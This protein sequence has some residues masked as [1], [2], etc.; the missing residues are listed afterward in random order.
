MKI[1]VNIRDNDKWPRE[2]VCAGVEALGH[3][4]TTK[5]KIADMLI[6]WSP[7]IGSNR[8]AVMNHYIFHQKPILIMENGWIPEI[9]E[10]KYYQVAFNGWNG[11]GEFYIGDEKRWNSWKLPIEPWRE[12]AL[13]EKKVL[14]ISQNGH[15]DD[16][17]TSPIGWVNSVEI[18]TK[19]KVVRTVKKMRPSRV[20]DLWAGITWSSNYAADLIRRG[21]PVFAFSPS[22]EILNLLAKQT[23]AKNISKDLENSYY[24][25]N[26]L[27]V[28]KDMAW[29][30][31]SEKE[32][33]TGEP[34]RLQIR[35]SVYASACAI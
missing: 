35:N 16:D 27:E 28:F 11:K 10:E 19:R 18:K 5:S 15:P 23:N 2:V 29:M 12:D 32:L 33:A 30:Q 22:N 17:R 34:F 8:A 7:W 25:E 4:V 6:T 13:N 3:E 26:R 14:V 9:R 21:I 20:N 1:F 24:P 31:W